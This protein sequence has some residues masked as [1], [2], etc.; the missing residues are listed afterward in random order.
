MRGKRFTEEVA[1]DV[2]E[3][4]RDLHC[5]L[6][7]RLNVEVVLYP[8]DRRTRDLDNYMKALLDALTKARVWED[9][10]LIDQLSILRGAVMSGGVTKIEIGPAGPLIP[11]HHKMV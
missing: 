3:Q 11:P 2:G 8:P 1:R 4:L 7:Y 10:C 6:D 9:D 5:P